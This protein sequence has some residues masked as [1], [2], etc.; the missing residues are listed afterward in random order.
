MATDTND[1]RG[2][3]I[4]V[5]SM[6]YRKAQSLDLLIPV[7]PRSPQGG[8]DVGPLTYKQAHRRLLIKPYEDCLRK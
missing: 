8:G 3:Q 1:R 5:L 4:K 2:Q 6:L 7:L